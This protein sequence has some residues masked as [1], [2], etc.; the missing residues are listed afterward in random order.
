MV[1]VERNE[2]MMSV[3]V[4]E[5]VMIRRSVRDDVGVRSEAEVDDDD[6]DIVVGVSS[7]HAS[8]RHH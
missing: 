8:S 1:V 7:P 2:M 4:N 6:D 3:V 5:V